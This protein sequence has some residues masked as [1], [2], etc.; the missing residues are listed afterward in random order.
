MRFFVAEN[1]PQ[2]DR[3]FLVR[4]ESR[5]RFALGSIRAALSFGKAAA[6]P[7]HSTG[8]GVD[9]LEC[10]W[11]LMVGR[12]VGEAEEAAAQHFFPL[13]NFGAGQEAESSGNEF[14]RF[15]FLWCGVD[16]LCGT[17]WCCKGNSVRC[18]HAASDRA[19]RFIVLGAKGRVDGTKVLILG[20]MFLGR[21]ARRIP[22]PP[23]RAKR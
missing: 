18:G 10:A 4:Q 12:V 3:G 16:R 14:G 9:S 22:W 13:A 2:N 17:C 15:V 20:A 6:E 11:V 21:S 23:F 1:A 8:L 19:G 5:R 7:P